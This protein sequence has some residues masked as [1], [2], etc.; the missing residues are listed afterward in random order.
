MKRYV[1]L[2][3]IATASA[4]SQGGSAGDLVSTGPNSWL[5]HTPEE[6]G[7]LHVVPNSGS[8]WNWNSQTQF[9]PDGRVTFSSNVGVGLLYTAPRAR[10]DVAGSMMLGNSDQE[11]T[12]KFFGL[13]GDNPGGYDHTVI[14]E[15]LYGGVDLAE[16]L[17]FKG[18]DTDHPSIGDRIRFDTSGSIVFQTGGGGRNYNPSVEGPT[19]LIIKSDG[20][21]GIG[22]SNPVA[23]LDVKNGNSYSTAGTWLAA[24]Q[25][26][27]NSPGKNGLTVMN[28]WAASNSTIFEAA[29]GWNGTATGYFPVFTIDGLGRVIISPQRS[30]AMRVTEIGNVGIGETNPQHKL[31]VNGTIKAKEIIVETTGWSDYVFADSYALTPLTEVEAH[32]KEHKHLPG[33]PSAAQVA[34]QGVSLGEMQAR[35]LAKIEELTLHLVIQDKRT[36]EQALEI[37]ELRKELQS[38]KH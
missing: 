33:I 26:N 27:E 18:N 2:L 4:Y 7:N 15:R 8:T 9:Y 21:V 11:T 16:L 24:I 32:I 20:N 6:N 14:A 34:E 19:R 13:A 12:I 22:T 10:L 38:L 29:M 25:Q 1:S 30:E 31:A 36:S 37:A 23:K 3:F 28:A 5:F 17:F 35:L